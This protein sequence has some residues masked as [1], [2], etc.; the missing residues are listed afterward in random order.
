M[1][2]IMTVLVRDVGS[3]RGGLARGLSA[4]GRLAALQGRIDDAVRSDVDLIRLGQALGRRVPMIAYMM[5]I[6]VESIG[7]HHLRDIRDKLNQDQCRRVIFILEAGDGNRVRAAEVATCETQFMNA[8]V[9]KMGFLP[10]ISMKV[11]GVQAKQVAEATSI[12]DSTEKRQN[13]ARRLLL[14]DLA[15]RVYRQEHGSDPPDLNA[16]VPS[17]LKSVPIDPY[18]DRPLQYRKRGKDGVAYSFGPDRDDDMLSKP[19]PVK[20][21]DTTDGDFTIDS[22]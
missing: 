18:S 12:L 14:T 5:S 13:A 11:T 15:I 22:F 21:V 9:R 10:R 17:I 20:H 16:L 6:A 3:I 7:L 2:Y 4:E 19:L 8:N 1:D